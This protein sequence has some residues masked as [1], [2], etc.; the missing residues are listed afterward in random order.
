MKFAAPVAGL[1][2]A[3]AAATHAPDAL[4]YSQ[5]VVFGDSLSDNGNLARMVG[6]PAE[7]YYQGRFSNGPVAVEVMSSQLGLTLTDY[8]V[9][10]AKTGSGG[11]LSQINKYKNALAANTLQPSA[12]P[13]DSTLYFVW[14]GPNDFFQGG[15]TTPSIA[16][17]AA[18]NLKAGITTLYGLGARDFFVPLMPDLGLTPA[19]L[20]ANSVAPGYSTAA[21]LMSTSFNTL[22]ATNLQDLRTTLAGVN[23]ITFDTQNYLREQTLA[24]G[25]QS[26]NV[27]DQCYSGSYTTEGTVCADPDHYLFW[28]GVH[29]TAVAHEL[30]GGAFAQ[31]VP[32][33]ESWMMLLLGVGVL[34]AWQ[35]RR[36]VAS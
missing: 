25:S 31:A 9:G 23:I 7:P 5:I 30:L 24:L 8:A 21:S 3:F 10:G 33:P 36:G 18:G 14:G 17:T 22:L 15:M 11:I 6:L 32:E 1:M 4:A 16:T 19:A 28:D 34:A 12:Q 13:G 35:R 26:F 2:L 20:Q 29:P 27:T